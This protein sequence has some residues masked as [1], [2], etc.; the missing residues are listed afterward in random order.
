MS[1]GCLL[2]LDLKSQVTARWRIAGAMLLSF[3]CVATSGCGDGLAKVSGQITLNGQ[4]LKGGRGDVR[5]T[6][7]FQPVDGVGANA[8]GLADE[9]GNY[10]VSTGSKE[11][12]QPGEYYV[13]C[14]VSRLKKPPSPAEVP[15][16]KFANAKTSGLKVLVNPGRNEYNIPL[17]SSGKG[18]SRTVAN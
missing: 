4:P 5:V 12:I 2:P 11:G 1:I 18:V 8:I 13:T 14:S 17:T 3:A 6:M 16:P 15:D 9:N 7:Q 10:E